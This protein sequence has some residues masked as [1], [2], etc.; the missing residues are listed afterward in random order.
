MIQNV[1]K[2][3]SF[4]T[5]MPDELR[6]WYEKEAA[7]CKRSL[8]FVIVEALTEHKENKIKKGEEKKIAGI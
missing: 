3:K 6:K 8:N 7:L 2:I 5:R 1:C 4:P